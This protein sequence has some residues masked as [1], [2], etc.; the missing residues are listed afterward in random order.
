MPELLYNSSFAIFRTSLQDLCQKD[1]EMRKEIQK[2]I[3][4]AGNS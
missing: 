4:L 3:T 1:E 2:N